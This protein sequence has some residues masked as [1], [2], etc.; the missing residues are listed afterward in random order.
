MEHSVLKEIE[1]NYFGNL[2][3]SLF[4]EE[5]FLL[6]FR[7]IQFYGFFLMIVYETFPFEVRDKWSHFFF[8]MT[9]SFQFMIGQEQYYAVIQSFTMIAANLISYV[10]FLVVIVILF[11]AM[12]LNKT[13]NYRLLKLS[14][15]FYFF[16]WAFWFME[17]IY[18]PLLLN[19]VEFATCDYTS[20]R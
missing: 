10:A 13:L 8:F 11:A 6:I 15:G 9:G 17:L 3:V 19:I 18:F 5:K 1:V 16:K 14:K 2:N 20:K 12:M 4:W 7:F